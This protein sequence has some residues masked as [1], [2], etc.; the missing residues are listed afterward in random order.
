[1]ALWT[2]T[3]LVAEVVGR[4]EDGEGDFA[5]GR[6]ATAEADFVVDRFADHGGAGTAGQGGRRFA[7]G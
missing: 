2:A 5:A 6:E 1:L 3:L 7:Y 4:G